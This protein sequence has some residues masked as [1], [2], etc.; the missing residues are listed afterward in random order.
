MIE[1]SPAGVL[2]EN[3]NNFLVVSNA[4]FHSPR[5][6]RTRVLG[7][8]SISFL[9]STAQVRF[10]YPSVILNYESNSIVFASAAGAEGEL[11][12]VESINYKPNSQV[13]DGNYGRF[14]AVLNYL[15]IRDN[16]DEVEE[17]TEADEGTE[18]EGLFLVE[19]E[20]DYETTTSF[21]VG[22]SVRTVKTEYT[23]A[24]NL[25][26]GSSHQHTQRDVQS[27]LE[28]LDEILDVGYVGPPPRRASD[29]P[30]ASALTVDLNFSAPLWRNKLIRTI[31]I[32]FLVQRITLTNKI[33]FRKH[34]ATSKRI[35]LGGSQ[36]WSRPEVIE[37]YV[38][39][40]RSSLVKQL[41]VKHDEIRV[42]L[43]SSADL[44]IHLLIEGY[45]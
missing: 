31:E 30:L 25:K 1:F 2:S 28:E 9:A 29:R 32:V 37:T 18:T 24:G 12:P 10:A 4:T 7:D 15:L 34:G 42:V 11:I 26:T 41:T 14:Y 5:N 22:S 8:D 13:R 3:E 21:F 16:S 39:R 35:S 43:S 20:D 38:P 23:S 17:E 33:V 6:N 45:A 19:L 36:Y 27:Y 44:A 40:H